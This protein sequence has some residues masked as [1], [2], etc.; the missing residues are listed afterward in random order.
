MISRRSFVKLA[1]ASAAMPAVAAA[2]SGRNGSRAFAF[3]LNTATIRGY[4]LPLKEQISAA[5]RAGFEGIEPW[6]SDLAAAEKTTGALEDARKMCSD[7]GLQVVSAIGFAQWAVNDP[8]ERA[9]GLEQMKRDM[10][11]VAKIGGQRIAAPPAGVYNKE[12]KLELDA[13][14]ER[15]RL[16]L[17]LGDQTGVIPQVEF[18]GKSANISTL[19]QALY[20]A[21]AASHP[22]ACVLADV[23]H[24]Y[25]G[26]SGFDNLRVLTS[27]MSQVFHMNDYPENPPRE[28][29]QDSDRVWPGDGIAPMEKIFGHFRT[30]AVYPWLS[31][32]LF[33]PEYWKLPIDEMLATGLAKLRRV[34]QAPTRA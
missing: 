30:N 29:A 15:Y 17:E 26:N 6:V 13:A 11:L 20:I 31:L 7:S 34:A 5:I 4:R 12:V 28:K 25:M 19:A 9:K 3:A 22:K 32:E 21:V 8:A 10:E 18:W 1:A 27:S 33:N 16:V 23:F 24:M 2:A 14:A